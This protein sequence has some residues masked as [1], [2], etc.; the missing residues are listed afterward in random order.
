V[1]ADSVGNR[2]VSTRSR[3]VVR[4][5][6][7]G[8]SLSAAL[9]KSGVLQPMVIEMVKVGESTGALAEMLENVA[10]YYD[11]DISHDL[12]RLLTLLE[13]LLLIFMGGIVAGM[14]IAMYL[15]LFQLQSIAQ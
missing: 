5:I 4:N 12:Q 11:E 9:D 1:A 14:L 7:E 15:P 13:P 2:V 8:E 6:R 3:A 10:E